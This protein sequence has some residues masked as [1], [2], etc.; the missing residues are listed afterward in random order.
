MTAWEDRLAERMGGLSRSVRARGSTAGGR[1]R[2][3]PSSTRIAAGVA[4]VVLLYLLPFASDYWI[5]SFLKPK[6]SDFVSVLFFPISIYVLVA[7]GLNIVVGETGL[8]D[9]G[10][11]AF[12]AVGA[13]T[14]GV[15]GSFHGD[16]PWPLLLPLGL[17][18][19]L[20]AGVILG[21]PTLRLRGDYLAIVTLGFG[22]IIRIT[23]NNLEWLGDAR[24]ISNIPKP[25][26]VGPL[27]FKLLDAK[28]YYWLSLT[29]IIIVVFA[30]RALERS[31]VGRYWTAIREDEDA[32]ELM[33]VPTF[34]YKLWAFASG[35][36]L[37]GLSGVLFASKVR[38][39]NPDSF[40]LQLS[41]LFLAA[42]VLGGAGNLPGV[43]LGAVVVGY[44]PE[45]FRFLDEQRYFFFGIALVL[46]MIFRP[47]GL[48]PRK[49]RGSRTYAGD[50][51]VPSVPEVAAAPE[52][53]S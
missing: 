2:A 37:G 32:A 3:M 17:I 21:I 35:A 49:V 40:P 15:L 12:F 28:P 14:T 13:Y 7:V 9:L 39:I 33:G 19:A 46:T 44:L 52:V 6:N 43:I 20:V 36:A 26:N 18:C 8:L 4:G 48:L 53:A 22:E 42:V 29:L 41:I 27:H 31:R 47:Q 5:F 24:G 1:W 34:H 50:G 38:F 16:L 10:Y 45:R 25:P 23:A 30:A 51:T 11:V